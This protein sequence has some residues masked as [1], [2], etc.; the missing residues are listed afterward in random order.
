[1]PKRTA[2]AEELDADQRQRLAE[3]LGLAERR[4]FWSGSPRTNIECKYQLPDNGVVKLCRHNDCVDVQTESKLTVNGLDDT[5]SIEVRTL[6]SRPGAIVKGV[7]LTDGQVRE[8]I[9]ALEVVMPS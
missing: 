9:R 8:L 2:G 6:R 1:M 4:G 3:A 5:G 7:W